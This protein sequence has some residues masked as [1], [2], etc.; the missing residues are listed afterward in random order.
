[1]EF[2]DMNEWKE[3]SEMNTSLIHDSMITSSIKKAKRDHR[4]KV[5]QTF[6]VLI[7]V[8]ILTFTILVNTNQQ[9]VSAINEM[10]IMSDLIDM[11]KYNPSIYKARNTDGFQKIDKSYVTDDYTLYLE[12]MVVDED[13]I[14]IYYEV[15]TN[16]SDNDYIYEMQIQE[17]GFST[18][19]PIG[20]WKFNELTATVIDP[21]ETI[22][23]DNFTLEFKI[24]KSTYPNE[25]IGK[26]MIV[27]INNDLSKIVKANIT[28][29]NQEMM[30]EDQK[31][32]IEKIEV[33]PLRS[34][35]YIEQDPNNSK[36][37]RNFE[38]YMKSENGEIIEEVRS[39]IS[40]FGTNDH[41]NAYVLE[42]PYTDKGKY[43]IF[44]KNVRWIN[45][46]DKEIIYN[47]DTNTCE[48]LPSYIDYL[49]LNDNEIRFKVTVQPDSN[50]EFGDYVEANY[51]ENED[52]S[53]SYEVFFMLDE[54]EFNE[55]S[56]SILIDRTGYIYEVNEQITTIEIK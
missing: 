39:G 2:K 5:I 19:Y 56:E 33:L 3:N 26:T 14:A 1:M 20:G 4:I 17:Y 29:I 27:E 16:L 35:V 23:L 53:R 24:E 38:L 8:P 31:V 46:D 25:Q 15:K 12:S 45:K 36:E 7:F 13:Q 37:I 44:I 52:G 47:K 34:I 6:S 48:N 18:S 43:D 40:S 30:I 11:F 28:E 50:F 9:F 54:L 55:N 21:R 41:I 22:S 10:P 49:G 32:I 42:S 51:T